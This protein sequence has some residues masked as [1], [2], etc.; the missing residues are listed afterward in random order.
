M[1][2]PFGGYVPD[3][4]MVPTADPAT[5]ES[6]HAELVALR[7]EL[8]QL[9]AAKLSGYPLLIQLCGEGNLIEAYLALQRELERH[10]RGSKFEAAASLSITAPADTVLDRL[11]IEP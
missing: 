8:G 6:A 2:E 1:E 3:E 7:G 5:I 9:S 11:T 4:P 10:R